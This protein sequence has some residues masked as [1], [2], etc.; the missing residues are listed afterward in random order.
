[1]KERHKMGRVRS[2]DINGERVK[3]S[4]RVG[5]LL[6]FFSLSWP[7]FLI[8]THSFYYDPLLSVLWRMLEDCLKRA[9][10]NLR[11]AKEVDFIFCQRSENELSL[12]VE[13]FQKLPQKTENFFWLELLLFVL[14]KN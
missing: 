11:S 10:D 2:K 14:K 1:M 13:T 5:F 7:F 8:M 9:V 6:L 12:S 4:E 3:E